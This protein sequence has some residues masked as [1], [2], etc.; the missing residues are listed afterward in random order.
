MNR[1]NALIKDTLE[2]SLALCKDTARRQLSMNQESGPHQ[3]LTL[4]VPPEL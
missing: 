2:S 3:T 4:P 1:I